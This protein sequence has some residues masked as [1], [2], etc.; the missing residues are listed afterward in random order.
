[1][2]TAIF[3]AITQQAVIIRNRRFGTTYQSHLK[4]S[5]TQEFSLDSMGLP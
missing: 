3:W 4:G 2:R 5:R 1:M